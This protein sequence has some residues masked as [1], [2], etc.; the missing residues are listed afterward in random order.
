MPGPWDDIDVDTLLAGAAD[1][2]I[3]VL[4][5]RAVMRTLPVLTPRLKPEAAQRWSKEVLALFRALFV[6]DAIQRHGGS[7]DADP[8]KLAKLPKA[9]EDAADAL[10][11][12]RISIGDAGPAAFARLAAAA[13]AVFTSMTTAGTDRRRA[14]AEAIHLAHGVS[15]WPDEAR[16]AFKLDGAML[17]T[18]R[19]PFVVA[20]QPLWGERYPAEAV[21]A[22]RLFLTS[23]IGF[24]W[25][26]TVWARW[27]ASRLRGMP[28]F[29]FGDM[30]EGR[31][32]DLDIATAADDEWQGEPHLVNARI[33]K[34]SHVLA[35]ID[36]II[37]PVVT[38]DGERFDIVPDLGDNPDPELVRIIA[39][40]ANDVQTLMSGHAED[41]AEGQRNLTSLLT[42][43]LAELARPADERSAATI[44]SLVD[45]IDLAVPRP[46]S[47]AADQAF[48]RLKESRSSFMQ[49]WGAGSEPAAPSR[50]TVPDMMEL[51]TSIGRVATSLERVSAGFSERLLDILQAQTG[52]IEAL[53]KA[54]A[55]NPRRDAG[56]ASRSLRT[57][58]KAGSFAQSLYNLAGTTATLGGTQAQQV[59]WANVRSTLESVLRLAVPGWGT[60]G[61]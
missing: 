34:R 17:E 60:G 3:P 19:G 38:Y 58:S 54:L 31:D 57:A 14:A 33:S 51:G 52:A 20:R 21:T 56:W 27:Y 40:M 42:A 12:A 1:R 7:P 22:Q 26:W 8:K 55:A 9:L 10:K 59:N 23:V 37:A 61:T 35:G 49:R 41:V 16:L 24:P 4:A 50:E 11:V 43:Y 45:L 46:S 39:S 15:P 48:G 13:Q 18:A 29:G 36:A 2:D 53:A 30:A 5:L 32:A 28:G 44:A 6:A 47:S 25:R